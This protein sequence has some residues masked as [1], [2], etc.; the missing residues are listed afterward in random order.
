MKE[1]GLGKAEPEQ[2]AP[3]VEYLMHSNPRTTG[4]ADRCFVQA[5]TRQD[6]E[7]FPGEVIGIGTAEQCRE[8]STALTAGTMT[9]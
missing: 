9:V 2:A 4:D 1:L 8:V 6:G 3:A 5:Y 7:L